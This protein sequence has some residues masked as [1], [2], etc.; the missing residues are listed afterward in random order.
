MTGCADAGP[1]RR[2]HLRA[3]PAPL[4]GAR[5]PRPDGDGR[6]RDAR[7]RGID[8]DDARGRR[9]A[10]RGRDRSHH[11]VVPQRPLRR[12]QD[13]RGHGPG[14]A[15]A[16]SR[17]RGRARPRSASP[18]GRWRSRR[19]TTAWRPARTSPGATR[20]S[21]ACS[22][23][24][25]TR[26]WASAWAAPWCS[27]TGARARSATPTACARSSA[28]APASIPDFLALV[29]DTADG[30]PGIKGWGAKSTATVLAHYE[31]LESIPD[32]A[33]DWDV[34]VRGAVKLADRARTTTAPTPTCSRC[35][36][37]SAPIT[38]SVTSTTGAGP[39]PAP[40]FAAWT[41]RLGAPGMLRRVERL[42]ERRA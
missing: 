4:R 12:L 9:D 13:R 42:A 27:S 31:H 18:S 24:R 23:A 21:S 17:P 38:P 10:P 37:R 16:V 1:S 14:A 40:D 25:P 15:R 36:R 33:K 30:F 3:V 7:R 29:G 26:T 39:D 5:A 19:P 34:E 6:R 41:E 28:S 11:R 2:R 22:S 20:V 32:L 8:A 35:S